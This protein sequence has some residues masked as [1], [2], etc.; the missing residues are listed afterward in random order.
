MTITRPWEQCSR[1]ANDYQSRNDSLL[2]K[3]AERAHTLVARQIG[4]LV[5]RTNS[6]EEDL[7]RREIS[8]AQCSKT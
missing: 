7:G 5:F 8:N 4:K 2:N 6:G 3:R 1:T